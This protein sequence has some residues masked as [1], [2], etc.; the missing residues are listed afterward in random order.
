MKN[1]NIMTPI[2]RQ[3]A[4]ERRISIMQKTQSID[5]VSD[6]VPPDR[7]GF[8]LKPTDQGGKAPMQCG[9]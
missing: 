6:G 5:G 1:E 8:D 2:E 4:L 9:G 7:S 3:N